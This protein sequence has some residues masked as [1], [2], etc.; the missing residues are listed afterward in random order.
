MTVKEE[1]NWIGISITQIKKEE[2]GIRRT[3]V[4][5][6]SDI[7]QLDIANRASCFISLE[8]VVK[9]DLGKNRQEY[10][11]KILHIFCHLLEPHRY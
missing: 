7:H 4:W 6:A 2:K 5:L 11:P 8:V 3:W 1:V 10:P 9:R